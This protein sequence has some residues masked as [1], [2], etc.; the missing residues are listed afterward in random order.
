MLPPDGLGRVSSAAYFFETNQPKP[1]TPGRICNS[2][3][4]AKIIYDLGL[5]GRLSV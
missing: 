5:E 2:K 3:E 1:Y 4:N